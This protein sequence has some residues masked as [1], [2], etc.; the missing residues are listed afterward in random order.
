MLQSVLSILW[1]S[2]LLPAALLLLYAFRAEGARWTRRELLSFLLAA[3]PVLVMILYVLAV[4]GL[5][6]RLP[7]NLQLVALFTFVPACTLSLVWPRFV[8]PPATRT[9]LR[10]GDPDGVRLLA[11]LLTGSGTPLW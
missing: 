1:I 6:P 8:G 2:S 10:D 7:P 11:F 9:A 4:L 5:R 3:A